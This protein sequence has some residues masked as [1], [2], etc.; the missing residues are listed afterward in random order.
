MLL[1][2]GRKLLSLNDEALLAVNKH[3]LNR[4]VNIGFQEDFSEFILPEILGRFSRSFPQI[5][6]QAQSERNSLLHDGV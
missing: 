2:Y 1:S 4:N 3:N 5:E 6:I